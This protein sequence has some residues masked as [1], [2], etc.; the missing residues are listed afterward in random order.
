MPIVG[1][2]LDDRGRTVCAEAA[3]HC[4]EHDVADVVAADPGVDDGPPGDDLAV[5][6][7]DDEGA[8]DDVAIPAAELEDLLS[9]Q[10]LDGRSWGLIHRRGC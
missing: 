3:F 7:V 5:M 10:V 2:H 8:A 1:Q 6:R 9:A 4:F